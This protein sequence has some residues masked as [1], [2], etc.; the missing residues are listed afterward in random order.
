MGWFGGSL[1]SVSAHSR[2]DLRFRQNLWSKVRYPY[3]Y[4]LAKII[5]KDKRFTTKS[6]RF[7]TKCKTCYGRKLRAQP[8]TGS[9]AARSPTESTDG[10]S[11]LSRWCA[12]S[13]YGAAAGCSI[14]ATI[15]RPE[16][17]L[18]MNTPRR[19]QVLLPH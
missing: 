8:D 18:A 11:T 7:V 12:C 15:R 14:L 6:K 3:T 4:D 16:G 13:H 1:P 2:S 10:A 5:T 9:L 17:L 19:Q